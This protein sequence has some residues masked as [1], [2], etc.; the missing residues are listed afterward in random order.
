MKDV[1]MCEI[2]CMK[3]CI[4]CVKAHKLQRGQTRP[5]F[6]TT[7]I[8]CRMF[9]DQLR[10]ENALSL[11][12][13]FVSLWQLVGIRQHAVKSHSCVSTRVKSPLSCT[14]KSGNSRHAHITNA[15]FFMSIYTHI[16]TRRFVCLF[17]LSSDNLITVSYLFLTFCFFNLSLL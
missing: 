4:G 9:Q 5:L 3:K 10:P 13:R 12:N 17:V 11:S 16:V 6:F 2:M 14:F 8:H 1:F 15:L 7:L